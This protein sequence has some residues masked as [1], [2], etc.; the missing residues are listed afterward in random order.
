VTN[1][2]G[3]SSRRT[4]TFRI[5]FAVGAESATT[6]QITATVGT[7]NM[8][9]LTA[10]AYKQIAVGGTFGEAQYMSGVSATDI[11]DGNIT[12]RIT[13]DNTVNRNVEGYYRVSYAVTDNDRNTA[14]AETMVFVG[15]WVY[16]DGYLINA[17]NF[18]KRAGQVLGTTADMI[19]SA[20]A[21]A[22]CVIKGN[23]NYGRSVPVT[24]TSD[25]GYPSKKPGTYRISLA[26]QADLGVSK[27]IT[28]TVTSGTLPVLTVP[29]IRTVPEGGS[30]S[31]LQGVTAA[32]A[33]DGNITTKVIYERNVDTSKVGA[34]RVIYSVT[35]SDGNTV[36]RNGAV[37]VG[38]GW[39]RRGGYALYAESFARTLSQISG[40]KG[41]A[42]RLA[43]ARAVWI[44]DVNSPDFVKY[45]SVYVADTGGYK[46][47]AGTYNIKFAISERTSVTQ[48]VRAS[49][50]DTR[51]V[52]NNQVTPPPVVNVNT[53]A[54]TPPTVINNPAPDISIP[55]GAAPIVNVSTPAIT[56]APESEIPTIPTPE[57]PPELWHLIDL[58]LAII[59]VALGFYLMVFA[60]R[61]RESEEYEY[62][63]SQ[64]KRIMMWG[65]L[66]MVFSIISVIILILTQ[67]FTGD[68]SLVDPWAI[69]FGIIAGAEALAAIGVTSSRRRQY[70]MEREA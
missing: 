32:D 45:V 6:I 27:T 28:A 18:T 26:V 50:T 3:Y 67:Q 13:H 33:E 2:G 40:T 60:M 25:G 69:V 11:E 58:I 56:T 48:T 20:K 35:D 64:N 70:E 23:P 15:S 59:A 46:K 21:Q 47:A 63:S 5:T 4:G 53:P 19:G 14:R 61:R 34:Y 49:I 42:I 24:V 30:F 52:I 22:V 8:P 16:R 1:D 10:P 54:A 55:P 31:Y 17:A 68:M 7:G 57:G 41:E 65:T 37:L 43:R 39:V 36:T 62:E 44:Q 66:G 51:T 29:S 12:S 38:S 9:T